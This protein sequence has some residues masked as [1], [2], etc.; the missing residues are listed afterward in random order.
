MK[1][2]NCVLVYDRFRFTRISVTFVC[3]Y[4]CIIRAI[5]KKSIYK[6]KTLPVQSLHRINFFFFYASAGYMASIFFNQT[7]LVQ[8]FFYACIKIETR[9][10]YNRIKNL[11]LVSLLE[12]V[13]L[14][15]KN[16]KNLDTKPVWHAL[17]LCGAKL[18]NLNCVLLL[19]EWEGVWEW[20]RL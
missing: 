15:P 2:S 10:F 14:I 13:S 5:I 12:T 20:N 8:F 9:N 3:N 17:I 4:H 1:V 11:W 18:L 6:K 16:L 7:F 19:R